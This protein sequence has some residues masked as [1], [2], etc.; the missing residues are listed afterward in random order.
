MVQKSVAIVTGIVIDEERALSLEELARACSMQSEWVLELVAEGII[1]AASREPDEWRF[2]GRSL[3]R[4]RVAAR[5]QR[6]LDVNL[7]GI[8][9]ALDLLQEI[10]D[11][12]ARLG[13]AGE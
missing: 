5:L 13:L 1:E 7:A 2:P 3:A 9:L 6:D 8:A 4:A 12:R 10:E 11:L